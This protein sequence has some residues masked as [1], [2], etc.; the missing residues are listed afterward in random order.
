ME[1]KVNKQ[2]YEL[3][4]N[5]SRYVLFK[6]GTR[7][8]K[9]ISI[10]QWLINVITEQKNFKIVVGV[11]NISNSLGTVV[12]DLEQ[13]LYNFNI[14][15][16]VKI[17]GKPNYV[18][19]YMP[20]KSQ[21]RFVS[22]DKPEKWFG[23]EADIVWFNESTHI[24]KQVFEQAE[25]RLPDRH[26]LNMMILDYNPTNPYSWVR[27]LESSEKP[28]GLSVYKSTYRDNAALGRKQIEL[29]ESF[30]ETNHN[31]YLVFSEG[32]Y[33]EVQGAIYTNWEVVDEFPEEIHDIWYGLDF[34]YSV[35]PSALIKVGMMNG[36]IYVDE[37]FYQ[38]HLTNSDI[39]DKFREL[40]ISDEEIIADSAEPKSIAEIKR[41]RFKIFPAKKG[42]DSI[43][44]GI[45]ILQRYKINITKRS[46]NTIDEIIN[47][48]W[49][50]DKTRN[51]HVG[52]PTE[53]WNHILDG[54]RYVALIKLGK[55]SSG[56]IRVF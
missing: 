39:C 33:G 3:E 14:I 42:P 38:T 21:I 44:N 13:W 19:E 37:M 1:I 11:Y 56:K 28:G 5:K 40:G 36:E 35:D 25:M 15:Q 20:T 17:K 22:C 7:S 2:F 52:I 43:K 18:Y 12:S 30:K 47:Y 26:P 24:D 6:G 8:G 10:I 9:T 32:E 55:K 54:L 49:K 23:L 45:D 53:N 46:K 48:S 50:L 27:D 16:L 41:E 4:N 34:G 51:E 29:I 31:K